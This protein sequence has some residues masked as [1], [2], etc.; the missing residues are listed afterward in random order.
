MTSS[1]DKDFMSCLWLFVESNRGRPV[2]PS[3]AGNPVQDIAVMFAYFV[4]NGHGNEFISK[5]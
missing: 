4:V 2:R 1:E 3:G 5:Y